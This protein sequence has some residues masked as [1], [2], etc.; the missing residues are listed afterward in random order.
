VFLTRTLYLLLIVLGTSLAGL[1]FPFTPRNNAVLALVTVG[2]PSLALVAWAR[3]SPASRSFLAATLRFAVPASLAV[4]AIAVPVYG[5]Y[6]ASA[7]VATARSAL[8]TITV[9]CG[10]L[11]IPFLSRTRAHADESPRTAA[12]PRRDVRPVLLAL[13]MAVVYG[14]IA[15]LPLSRAFF[16][17]TPLAA[18]DVAVLGALALAWAIALMAV[19]RLGVVERLQAKGPNANAG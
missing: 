12:V 17:L 10:L 2:L 11:L 16:D 8:V 4:A 3:P 9:F 13:A 5:A 19:R 1:A 7:S 6:L 14:V 18:S 15:T